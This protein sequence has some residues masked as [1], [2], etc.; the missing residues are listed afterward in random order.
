MRIRS[1]GIV[2]SAAL[3]AAAAL[4]AQGPQ[5]PPQPPPVFRGG[6]DLVE[7]DVVVH[8]K[9]GAF[10]SDLSAADFV[11]EESGAAQPIQQ[12]YLH[13]AT[14]STWATAPG[15]GRRR[16]DDFG[17]R[18]RHPGAAATCLCRRVR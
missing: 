18:R 7:V 4:I 11:V 2:A 16:D 8:G 9:D 15:S 17:R 3:W 1:A 5:N 6:T 13:L 14:Q 12:F 10:V